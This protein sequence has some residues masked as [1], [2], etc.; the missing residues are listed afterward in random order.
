M[1]KVLRQ[2]QQ[3]EE[4]PCQE[5]DRRCRKQPWSSKASEKA[6]ISTRRSGQCSREASET[7]RAASLIP[8]LD[9]QERLA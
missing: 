4:V 9:E 3:N 7:R 5:Q 8:G 6:T 2:E 1:G